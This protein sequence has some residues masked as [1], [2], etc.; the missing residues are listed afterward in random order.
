MQNVLIIVTPNTTKD[1]RSFDLLSLGN[2]EDIAMAAETP[3]IAIAPPIRIPNLF[4]RPN[5]FKI[6]TEKIIVKNNPRDN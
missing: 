4:G 5:N 3:H 6:K 1:N 2:T